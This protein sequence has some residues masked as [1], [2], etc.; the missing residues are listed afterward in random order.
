MHI[1]NLNAEERRNYKPG[2]FILY[3]DRPEP[4]TRTDIELCKFCGIRAVKSYNSK[5]CS[6][7]CINDAYMMRRKQRHEQALLKICS[8]CG[9]EYKAKRIDTKYCSCS[10]KQAAFRKQRNG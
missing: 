2:D 3:D 9:T 4:T 5:Y 6:Q 1:Q 7:R 8:F 10:C